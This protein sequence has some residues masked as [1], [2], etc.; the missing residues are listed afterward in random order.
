MLRRAALVAAGGFCFVYGLAFV[1][2]ALRARSAYYEGEKYMAWSR[3]PAL[4]RA[5]LA[6]ELAEREARLR[7]D[8]AAGRMDDAELSQRL[9]LARFD[10]DER[11]AESSVK[12]AYVWY[13]TAVELFSPPETR[14]VRLSREKMTRAKALW[15]LELDAQKIPYQDYMLE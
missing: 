10:F 5:A 13:Q 7:A 4:K 3:D 1:D 14:W 9:A 15:K 12:Y 2:V 8:R 6:Q 11:L